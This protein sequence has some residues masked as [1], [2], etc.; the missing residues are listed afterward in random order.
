MGDQLS[1]DLTM[2]G[3]LLGVLVFYFTSMALAEDAVCDVEN[4]TDLTVVISDGDSFKYK[5]S[6]AKKYGK[7][8]NCKVNYE[9]DQSCAEMELRCKKIVIKG[10]KDCSKGDKLM[11]TNDDGTE[12]VCGKKKKFVFK[13]SSNMVL[14]FTSDK[15]KSGPGAKGCVVQCTKAATVTT[16]GK[17]IQ[18]KPTGQP[19]EEC[20]APGQT[21]T[22]EWIS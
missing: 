19:I 12:T 16:A 3:L 9:L 22:F 2:K 6:S 1:Q 17:T 10:N 11:I 13:S 20:V 21:L 7:N 8:M 15:K 14:E 4:P 18:W 5:T